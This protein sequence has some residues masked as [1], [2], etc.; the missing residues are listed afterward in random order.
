MYCIIDHHEMPQRTGDSGDSVR[1]LRTRG[2][3]AA[4]ATRADIL[5]HMLDPSGQVPSL[6]LN[7]VLMT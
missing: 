5:K 4:T 6:V 2:Q 1:L 7:D 3:A